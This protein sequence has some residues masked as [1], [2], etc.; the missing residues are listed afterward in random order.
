MKLQT[1]LV[2]S[3]YLFTLTLSFGED[4]NPLEKSEALITGLKFYDAL[5]ALEPLLMTDRKSDE[6]EKA[7]WLANMLSEKLSDILDEEKWEAQKQKDPDL[8]KVAYTKVMNKIK[9]IN[10]YGARFTYFEMGAAI[11]I[12]M[13]S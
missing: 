9:T 1:F 12:I 13:A 4:K 6:Q 2:I 10:E 3:L 8:R 5:V 11:C 7:L